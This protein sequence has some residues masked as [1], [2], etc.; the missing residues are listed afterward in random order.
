MHKVLYFLGELTDRDVEWM[1]VSGKKVRLNTGDVLLREG[2]SVDGLYILL[3]GTLSVLTGAHASSEIA[4]LERGEVVGEMS[5][6]ES[7]PASA[8]V[9]AAEEALLLFL[10]RALLDAR[11]HEDSGFAAR[12]YRALSLFL[13]YRLRETTAMVGVS[14]TQRK[15]LAERSYD[16]LSLDVLDNLHSAG[17]RFEKMI[18]RLTEETR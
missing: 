3:V 8:T 16:E 10:P 15:N 7:R 18:R 2:R 14:A 11:L 1:I 17:T 5:F 6:I 9:Q 13:S 12:F 4:R